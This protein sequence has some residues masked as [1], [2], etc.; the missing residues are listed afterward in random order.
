VRLTARVSFDPDQKSINIS[1]YPQGGNTRRLPVGLIKCGHFLSTLIP[2]MKQL[3]LSEMQMVR[4]GSWACLD[5]GLGAMALFAETGI[6]ALFAG[7][8][9]YGICSAATMRDT[10]LPPVSTTL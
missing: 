8:I 6:G 5:S 3:Q 10:S 7:A 9:V 1:G 2:S 4:G